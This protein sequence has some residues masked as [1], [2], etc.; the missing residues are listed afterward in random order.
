MCAASRNSTTEKRLVFRVTFGPG[1]DKLAGNFPPQSHSIPANLA[2]PPVF[3]LSRVGIGVSLD[4]GE[5]GSEIRREILL[6]HCFPRLPVQ[7]NSK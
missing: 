5:D 4:F 6:L 2:I 7:V 3:R 1:H